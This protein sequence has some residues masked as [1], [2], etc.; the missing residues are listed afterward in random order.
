MFRAHLESGDN[1]G[2]CIGGLAAVDGGARADDVAINV[3]WQGSSCQTHGS[4]LERGLLV[5]KV[6]VA[7]TTEKLVGVVTLLREPS[8][9]TIDDL[10]RR[11]QDGQRHESDDEFDDLHLVIWILYE[12]EQSFGVKNVLFDCDG[13]E[14]IMLNMLTV[15]VFYT[16]EAD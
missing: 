16:R 11:G 1:F 6:L 9:L 15:D 14:V 2:A 7:L 12:R 10:D 4:D 5:L 13:A 8:D 3:S